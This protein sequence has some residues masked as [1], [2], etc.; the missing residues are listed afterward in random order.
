VNSPCQA[1]ICAVSIFNPENPDERGSS[2]HDARIDS[3]KTASAAKSNNTITLIAPAGDRISFNLSGIFP[4]PP[5][6]PAHLAAVLLEDGFE[7]EIFDLVIEKDPDRLLKERFETEPP[8]L[9]GISATIFSLSS[10]FEVAGRIR[11]LAPGAGIVLGGPATVFPPADLFARCG[12]LDFIVVGEGEMTLLH[13]ARAV[14][15]GRPPG[16]HPGLASKKGSGIEFSPPGNP[17]DL[18]SLPPPARSLLPNDIYRMHP[19]FGISPPA[20]LMETARGCPCQCSFCTIPG[21]LRTRSPERVIEEVSDLAADFGIREV[22]F[23]DPTFTWDRDRIREICAG[24][25]SMPPTERPA[26]SCKT[27]PDCVDASLLERMAAAG[28]YMISY[29]V[30]S[31][32]QAVLDRLDKEMNVEEME[33]ALIATRRAGIGSLVYL[34]VGSPGETD[35]TM[36]STFSLVRRTRP[37]YVLY[38]E[39]LPDPASRLTLE[40][41]ARG[42]FTRED[43]VNYYIDREVGPFTDVTLTG[44]PRRAVNGWLRR[45][46]RTFYFSP[47]F[48]IRQATTAGGL[49][50]VRRRLE[51]GFILGRELFTHMV[52]KKSF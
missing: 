44:L 20:T 10:A 32:S 19:P 29:G 33:T 25:M 8:A 1:L 7:V 18:D 41:V 24:L 42:E 50:Q 23:V 45:G 16:P 15:E 4:L 52:R 14:R 26:W 40:A 11:E 38:G 34:L 30:E 51:T 31:G 39:L 3:M 28:C 46:I 35:E 9:V 49:N 13:L 36:E 37:D 17:V 27:R 43:V 5:L 6:G 47:R 2:F 21:K 48:L 12:D 22:H